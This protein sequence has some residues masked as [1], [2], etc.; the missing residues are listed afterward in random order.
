MTGTL[1]T[2][3]RTDDGATQ[4]TYDGLPLYLFSGDTKPG[5]A[6]GVYPGWEAVQP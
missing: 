5:D 3:T 1:G 6:N 2:I 4:V